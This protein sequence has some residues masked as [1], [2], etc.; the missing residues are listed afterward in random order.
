MGVNHLVATINLNCGLL[1]TADDE[2]L[3][4]ERVPTAAVAHGS[5]S[6]RLGPN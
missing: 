2:L 3:N 4:L 1:E 5:G 6:G